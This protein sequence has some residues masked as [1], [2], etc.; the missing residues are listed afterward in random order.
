MR[1]FLVEPSYISA[2]RSF[3]DVQILC[4]WSRRKDKVALRPVL[5]RLYA[6]Q[7]VELVIVADA[8][9]CGVTATNHS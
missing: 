3:G 2:S 7:L 6:N 1:R 9:Y 5:R 8:I 4:T